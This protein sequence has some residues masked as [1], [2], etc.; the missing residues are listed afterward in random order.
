[1]Q[2]W[3]KDGPLGVLIY[4]INYNKT[5]QQ[6]ALFREFQRAANAETPARERFRVIKLVKPVV[7]CWNSYH[8]AFKRAT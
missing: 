7:T 2:E 3:R 5:L 8:A 1:L 6:Y 4:V